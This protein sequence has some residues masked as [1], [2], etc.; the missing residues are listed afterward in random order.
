MRLT[1]VEALL[2]KLGQAIEESGQRDWRELYPRRIPENRPTLTDRIQQLRND[3]G[4]RRERPESISRPTPRA[5]FE[6]SGDVVVERLPISPSGTPEWWYR[7]YSEGIKRQKGVEEELPLDK[8]KENLINLRWSSWSKASLLR[9][10][11]Y[12]D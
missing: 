3:Q 8:V 11:D 7:Q 2:E 5:G 12:E 1:A 6:A 4:G 9:R 10:S